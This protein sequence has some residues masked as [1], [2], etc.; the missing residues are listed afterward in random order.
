MCVEFQEAENPNGCAFS[1]VK[2]YADVDKNQQQPFKKPRKTSSR[3]A[4][5]KCKATNH[6]NGQMHTDAEKGPEYHSCP[7]DQ[8]KGESK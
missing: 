7:A 2:D 3:R 8:A 5:A 4:S 6:R 1:R